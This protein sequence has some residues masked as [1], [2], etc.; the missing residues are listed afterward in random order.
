MPIVKDR[1]NPRLQNI[2]SLN[3]RQVQFTFSEEIDTISLKPE[4]FLIASDQDTLPILTLYPSLSTRE[5]IAITGLQSDKVYEVSGYVY[6]KGENTGKFKRNFSGS[7]KTD[8]IAPWLVDYAKGKNTKEFFLK[9]SEAMD[10]AFHEFHIVPKK[11]FTVVWQNYRGCQLIPKTPFDSLHYDTT[12][13]FYIEKGFADISG[14]HLSPCITDITPDTIYNPFILRSKV[15][16]NDTLVKAG[17]AVLKRGIALAIAKV[18]NGEF[19]FEVRDSLPYGVEV[20]SGK[21]SGS[22]EVSVG[23]EDT[24]I[25]KAEEANIDSIIN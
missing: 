16:I 3:N 21:Y 10:T 13:Y 23:K 11:D 2:L 9:F 24:I 1:L 5:I 7:S 8:T 4:N 22:A 12:Y 6:D 14:N 25:L 19:A 20:I 18:E 17:L 15:M